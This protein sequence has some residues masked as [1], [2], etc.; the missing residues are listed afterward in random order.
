MWG[1]IDQK[2]ESSEVF[3]QCKCFIGSPHYPFRIE[4]KEIKR[5]G[6]Y[7]TDKGNDTGI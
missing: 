3:T 5:V 6:E 4:K 7:N 2:K 1:N